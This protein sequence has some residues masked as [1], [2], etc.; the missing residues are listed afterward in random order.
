[1]LG[2]GARSAKDPR[3]VEVFI[4]DEQDDPVVRLARR[5]CECTGHWKYMRAAGVLVGLGRGII[6]HDG[7][8]G[9]PDR[10][11]PGSAD[12]SEYLP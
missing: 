2:E 1:M 6:V 11:P 5:G 3:V 10:R 4:R 12:E 8:N 9:L 7:D